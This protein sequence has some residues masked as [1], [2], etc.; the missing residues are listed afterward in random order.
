MRNYRLYALGNLVS[1]TGTWMQLVAQNWLVLRMTDSASS[2]GVTV[3]L[4]S[5]PALLLGMH[6]GALADRLPKR[7]LHAATQVVLTVLAALL[8]LLAALHALQF[9]TIELFAVAVGAVS[10]VDGPVSGALGVELVSPEDLP[11]AAALGSAANSAGRI[12]GMS[13]AGVLVATTGTATVFLLNALSY[14]AVLVALARIRADEIR[15]ARAEPS[16]HRVRDAFGVVLRER[17]L[18]GVLVLAFAV[19]AFGRNYQVTMAVMSRAVFHAGASGYGQLS[20]VFAIGAFAGAVVAARVRSLGARVLVVTA[21]LAGALELLAGTMP[22]L[23]TFAACILPIAMTAVVIDTALGV[24]VALRVDEAY[25]GRALALLGLASMTGAT[26][27]APLLGWA[28]QHFGARLALAGRG[29][30]SLAIAV[31]VGLVLARG[32]APVSGDDAADDLARLHRAE[33]V[34][35]LVEVNAA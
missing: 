26:L 25:R 17:V 18:V 30:L 4:Q 22:G 32:R 2:L 27:G 1:V 23:G 29:A 3:A 6:G 20:T 11:N 8:A 14:V 13:L 21:V 35:D 12:L 16:R 34:V 10:A 9:W 19:A 33:G 24:V 31:A 7:A 15:C 28:A 5:A